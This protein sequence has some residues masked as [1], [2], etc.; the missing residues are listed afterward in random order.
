[1][2]LG[3]QARTTKDIDVDWAIGEDEAVRLLLDAAAVTLDG[4]LGDW[5]PGWRRLVANVPA[6]E[7]VGIGYATAASLLDSILK[8]ELASGTWDPRVGEWSTNRPATAA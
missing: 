4:P 8:N 6:E 5:G 3:A 2:R 1:M 7:D